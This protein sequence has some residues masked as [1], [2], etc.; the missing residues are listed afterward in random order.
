MCLNIN[1]FSCCTDNLSWK[2]WKLQN[3]IIFKPNSYNSNLFTV[4]SVLLL[5]GVI[6][7]DP[8]G[9][10]EEI[11]VFAMICINTFLQRYLKS[12]SEL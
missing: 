5:Y 12:W 6:Y 7:R 11:S 4:T 2:A 8:T 1:Y 10:V 3:L 9:S